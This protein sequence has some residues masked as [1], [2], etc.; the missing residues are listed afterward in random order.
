MINEGN[1]GNGKLTNF[2]F[3]HCNGFKN[4]DETCTSTTSY[5]TSTLLVHVYIF[6]D[7]MEKRKKKEGKY[8]IS[9]TGGL[10]NHHPRAH[11]SELL[12]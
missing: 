9:C 5:C 6:H 2:V 1:G 7:I 11:T 10:N 8:L 12:Y 4:G 3:G